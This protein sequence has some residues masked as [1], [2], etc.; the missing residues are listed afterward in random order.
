MNLAQ[1]FGHAVAIETQ[2]NGGHIHKAANKVSRTLSDTDRRRLV[3]YALV[4]L[5]SDYRRTEHRDEG[6]GHAPSDTHGADAPARV[7]I[8]QQLKSP[9]DLIWPIANQ[10][11]K[12]IGDW[13]G[14]DCRFHANY[15]ARISQT[16][17]ATAERFAVVADEL[18]DRT[19]EEAA[20]DLSATARAHLATEGILLPDP[21]EV[22][23]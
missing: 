19:I 18:G 4:N 11:R 6:G 23:A 17:A 21:K 7:P 8:R 3:H 20:G 12:R 14:A 13:T 2:N 9:Y 16:Y 1:Q 10:G 15:H 5:E 22:A